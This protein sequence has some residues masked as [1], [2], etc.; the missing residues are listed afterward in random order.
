MIGLLF[1]EIKYN[2]EY[3]PQDYVH[4]GCCGQRLGQSIICNRHYQNNVNWITVAQGS[5]ILT[6]I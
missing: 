6:N 4:Y 2:D 3:I 5:S 1:I